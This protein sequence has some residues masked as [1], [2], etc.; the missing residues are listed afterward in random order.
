MSYKGEGTMLEEALTHSVIGTFYEVHQGL[1]FGF[2]EY[3][4]ARALELD[5]MTRGHRV[6]REVAVPVYYRGKPLAWQTLDMIVDG[7]VVIE[8]K[9]SERLH[10]GSSQQL[11]SYLCSTNME[12]GLLLHFGREAKFQRVICESRFKRH[13][14]GTVAESNA[15][16]RVAPISG[17]GTPDKASAR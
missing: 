15:I 6:Q 9:A 1:G 12:V 2:R 10:P 13:K 16:P 7:K 5:L 14:E 8:T 17:A 11:F 3:I 4:Y